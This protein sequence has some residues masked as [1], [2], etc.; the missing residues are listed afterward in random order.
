MCREKQYSK[1]VNALLL[2]EIE[3]VTQVKIDFELL[4]ETTNVFYDTVFFEKMRNRTDLGMPS[5]KAR[6]ARR[7]ARKTSASRRVA[8]EVSK[9]IGG[10]HLRKHH[11]VD[12]K[13][14]ID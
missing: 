13:S 6:S 2:L 14:Q 12:R 10:K 8:K 11:P 1:K 5:R 3:M 9:I 7:A 4:G